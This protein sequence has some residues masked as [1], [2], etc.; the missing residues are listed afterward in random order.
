MVRNCDLFIFL[1]L[2]CHIVGGETVWKCDGKGWAMLCW[3]MSTAGASA[4]KDVSID[5]YLAP[6][7]HDLQF[8]SPQQGVWGCAGTP[9]RQCQTP[10]MPRVQAEPVQR[11]CLGL[12]AAEVTKSSSTPFYPTPL[13][14]CGIGAETSA[15]PT[16]INLTTVCSI[17]DISATT[18]GKGSACGYSTPQAWKAELCLPA[19]CFC[20]LYLPYFEAL[21]TGILIQFQW[22]LGFSSQMFRIIK[23]TS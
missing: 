20:C 3:V 9:E 5:V 19:L 6:L 12:P 17:L 8:C 10:Q 4:G 23:Y 1:S 2:L 21:I 14:R 13:A 15:F 18:S 11:Q 22:N 16:R 7:F